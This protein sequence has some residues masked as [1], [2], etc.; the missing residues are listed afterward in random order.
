MNEH[1]MGGA[2]AEIITEDSA[3][4]AAASLRVAR[5]HARMTQAH[6]AVASGVS[7]RTVV[8]AERGAR[9]GHESARALC[10]VLGLDASNL[11]VATSRPTVRAQDAAT[12]R[13]T[14]SGEPQTEHALVPCTLPSLPP[15]SLWRLAEASGRFSRRTR[16]ATGAPERCAACVGLVLL[17]VAVAL[18]ATHAGEGRVA[19]WA[20]AGFGLTLTGSWAFDAFWRKTGLYSEVVPAW[21]SGALG[22]LTIVIGTAP[23]FAAAAAI[24]HAAG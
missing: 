4:G 1:E 7:V 14:P 10:A 12:S 6:L 3:T 21:I 2:A 20:A 9:I 5:E 11:A 23:S 13:R 17:G 19:A 15:G 16:S 8:R 18:Y 22:W 24:V